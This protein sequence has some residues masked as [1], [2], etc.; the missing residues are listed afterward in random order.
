MSR[1]NDDDMYYGVQV[2]ITRLPSP[3]GTCLNASQGDE[4]LNVYQ[5]IH[6]GVEY[7]A[8]VRS[9]SLVR[10]R[11]VALSFIVVLVACPF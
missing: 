2:N 5:Q 6:S 10:S 1:D 7:S 4:S 9:S 3:F 11:H 8:L